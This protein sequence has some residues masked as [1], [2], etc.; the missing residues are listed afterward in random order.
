MGVPICLPHSSY[1][2]ILACIQAQLGQVPLS[3]SCITGWYLSCSAGGVWHTVGTTK[4]YMSRNRASWSHAR[5]VCSTLGLD[6]ASIKSAQVNS[7]LTAAAAAYQMN[8]AWLGATDATK[9]GEWMWV[10][11]TKCTTVIGG[12]QT[13]HGYNNWTNT[14]PNN[15]LNDEHCMQ[16]RDGTWNDNTCSKLSA[17][18]CGPG[19]TSAGMHRVALDS[20][21]ECQLAHVLVALGALGA[22]DAVRPSTHSAIRSEMMPVHADRAPYFFFT[23]A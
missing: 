12:V 8:P 9:E 5:A 23:S 2:H 13:A 22:F 17:F 18:I 7:N 15:A 19:S 11:G 14:E 1:T 20:L 4:Y 10:D 21:L 6:L 3:D 16:L